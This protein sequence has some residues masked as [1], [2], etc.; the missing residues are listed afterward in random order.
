MSFR[1]NCGKVLSIMGVGVM[2]V[3]TALILT[4]YLAKLI[5]AENQVHPI[6]AVPFFV[7]GAVMLFVGLFMVASEKW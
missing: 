1:K 5:G 6:Y 4:G 3:P 2:F 7:T